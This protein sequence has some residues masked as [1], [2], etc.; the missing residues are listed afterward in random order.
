MYRLTCDNESCGE[1]VDSGPGQPALSAKQRIY[2]EACAGYVA[3][4][5]AQLKTEM[6]QFAH[7]GVARLNA[8]R[9]ELLGQMLPKNRGGSDE[10]FQEW[11]QVG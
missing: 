8:R 10:R 9:Q 7:E 3:Q 11:P 5:E 4:A 2:C 1:E 6:V